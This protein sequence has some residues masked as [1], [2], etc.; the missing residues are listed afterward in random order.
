MPHSTTDADNLAQVVET[1]RAALDQAA[2]RAD[3]LKATANNQAALGGTWFAAAQA[4]A[5]LTL[6]GHAAQGWIIGLVIGA[7]SQA[8]ALC[9]LLAATTRVSKIH[10]R[11]EIGSD[12]LAALAMKASD[13]APQFADELILL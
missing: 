1:A 8:A 6:S 12:T 5:A 9:V 4:T 3:R 10:G 13:P 7:I 11:Q 2:Q